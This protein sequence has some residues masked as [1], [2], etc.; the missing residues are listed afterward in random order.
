VVVAL[1]P[2]RYRVQF[3]V[4]RETHDN[5]RRAQVL[6]RREIPDGDPGA[7]FHR[8]LKLLLDDVA[9]KKLAATST[10]RPIRAAA[11]RSRHIPAHIRRAVWLRDG[12]RCAFV[13]KSGR[14]CGESAFLEFHHVDPYAL[15]GETTVGNLVLHCRRHNVHE[16]ELLF[17]AF[18][19]VGQETIGARGRAVVGPREVEGVA[20]TPTRPGAS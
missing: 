4:G 18:V 8:A 20:V 9:R 6:L 1:A 3:T 7:I 2:E 14:R 11:A 19:P 5:L 10:P 15:G 16:S 17:G 13:G 12:G